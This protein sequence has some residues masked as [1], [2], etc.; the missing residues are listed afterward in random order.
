MALVNGST[1]IE[2]TAWREFIE[3]IH[4]AIAKANITTTTRAEVFDS[5]PRPATLGRAASSLGP[6]S[7]CVA[8]PTRTPALLTLPSSE[9]TPPSL[10]IPS[11]GA[12]NL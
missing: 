7:D 5:A 10:L 3:K 6:A 1:A 4:A 11:T 2:F 9:R 8:S 12:T